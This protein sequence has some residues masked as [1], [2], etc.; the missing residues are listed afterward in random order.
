MNS[1]VMPPGRRCPRARLAVARWPGPLSLC[2]VTS[3]H[4]PALSSTGC[5][6]SARRW[7]TVQDVTEDPRIYLRIAGELRARIEAGEFDSD[8][9]IPSVRTLMQEYGSLTTLPST[10]CGRL[11]GRVWSS[12]IPAAGST[13]P[14]TSKRTVACQSVTDIAVPAVHPRRAFP[15]VSMAFQ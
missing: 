10:R 5:K 7:A 11:R 3:L 14:G 8:G 12:A 6:G 13:S 9:K 1:W 15:Q 4:H 2:H